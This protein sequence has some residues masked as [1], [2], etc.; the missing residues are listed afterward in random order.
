MVMRMFNDA[1]TQQLTFLAPSSTVLDLIALRS[2]QDAQKLK[3]FSTWSLEDI[4]ASMILIQSSTDL[5]PLQKSLEYETLQLIGESVRERIEGLQGPVDDN[6]QIGEGGPNETD[7]NQSLLDKIKSLLPGG[8]NGT[9]QDQI[10][11]I[12]ERG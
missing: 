12:E 2:P 4:E 9:T 7:N 3:Y 6:A 5:T 8:G 1:K 11:A 10:T